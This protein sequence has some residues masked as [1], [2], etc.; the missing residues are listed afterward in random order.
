MQRVL[1]AHGLWRR[2]ISFNA[3]TKE[4]FKQIMTL[5]LAGL[6]YRLGVETGK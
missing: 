1:V 6:S 2:E 5:Y 3:D 4:Q